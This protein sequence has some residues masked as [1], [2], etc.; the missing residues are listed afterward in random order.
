MS[1]SVR[2]LMTTALI[3]CKSSDSVDEADVEMRLAAIR[4]IPI[5]DDRNHLV[6]VISNRDLLLA[7]NK[8]KGKKIVMSEVMSRDVVTVSEDTSAEEAVDI[9]IEKKFGCL[10]VTGD[11]GQLVGLITETDFLRVARDA[12]AQS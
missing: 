2:D 6:G 9:L 3:T 4:H 12:L 5:V 8:R 11:D 7:L 1:L 10:P